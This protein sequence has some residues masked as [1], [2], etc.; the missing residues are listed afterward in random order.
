MFHGANIY[1]KSILA[2]GP[3][4]HSQISPPFAIIGHLPLDHSKHAVIDPIHQDL[5]LPTPTDWNVHPDQINMSNTPHKPLS[6]S[7]SAPEKKIYIFRRKKAPSPRTQSVSGNCLEHVTSRV[8]KRSGSCTE[9]LV[10]QPIA[11]NWERNIY[12]PIQENATE[13]NNLLSP[14]KIRREGSFKDTTPRSVP[15][16]NFTR[17]SPLEQSYSSLSS[18]NT[19]NHYTS[20][21][22]SLPISQSPSPQW[23]PHTSKASLPSQLYP[24]TPIEPTPGTPLHMQKG[25]VGPHGLP[26]TYHAISSEPPT[27]SLLPL[28]RSCEDLLHP[29]NSPLSEYSIHR[30]PLPSQSLLNSRSNLTQSTSSLHYTPNQMQYKPIFP[31]QMPVNFQLTGQALDKVT[32]HDEELDEALHVLNKYIEQDVPRLEG[33]NSDLDSDN[34]LVISHEQ[35]AKFG[36]FSNS[37]AQI[38]YNDL[39]LQDLN[40]SSSSIKRGQIGNTVTGR[41]VLHLTSPLAACVAESSCFELS[42]EREHLEEGS[43]WEWVREL[44]G[45]PVD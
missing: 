38:I 23:N 37:Q 34:K 25:E 14:T 31:T 29:T 7:L 43:G 32:E 28:H 41:F 26:V 2:S 20:L 36:E 19:G 5:K 13:T 8:I 9:T 15:Q 27:P 33:D 24:N 35:L 44:R 3:K 45:F 18:T 21:T 11:C 39:K 12:P 22:N 10:N 1:P 4:Q 16:D 42:L 30:E 6:H 40:R 17:P